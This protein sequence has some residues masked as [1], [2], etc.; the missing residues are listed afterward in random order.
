MWTVPDQLQALAAV[1]R[2]GSFERAARSLSITTSAVSQRVKAIE[3]AAGRV[4]VRRERP[5]TATAAG[6]V[7]LKLAAQLELLEGD[8]LRELHIAGEHAV[9][10]PISVNADSLRTWLLPG[11]VSA[12]RQNG[13]T[14]DVRRED[15]DGAE[16]LL[17]DGEVMAA[18]SSDPDPVQGCAVVP[19]GALRYVPVAAASFRDEWFGAGFTPEALHAAPTVVYDR[20]DRLLD[21]F[22]ARYAPAAVPP[23]S[24]VPGSWDYPR[25]IAL[26][27][28]WGIVPAGTAGDMVT[29]S[30]QWHVDSPLFWHHWRLPSTHLA[31]LGT[32]VATAARGVLR[33]NVGRP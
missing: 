8:A 20:A 28:G 18:I 22:L 21:R 17:R 19:L 26:G 30:T 32:A 1:V 25:A 3:T 23:R 16:R 27:L 6:R 9:T 31:A 12:A 24:F 2:E 10:V 7:L 13:F 4:L 15:Q 11:L 33:P 5:V 14:L 29:L